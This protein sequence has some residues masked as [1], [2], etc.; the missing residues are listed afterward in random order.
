[1]LCFQ[2]RN[3]NKYVTESDG[4]SL[5]SVCNSN[6]TKTK[7][8]WT[9]NSKKNFV[10]IHK[11]THTQFIS[12]WSMATFLTVLSTPTKITIA[13]AHFV[14]NALYYQY[15]IQNDSHWCWFVGNEMNFSWFF[16]V[17]L[18]FGFFLQLSLGQIGW[19]CEKHREKTSAFD[20]MTVKR[21][22][23]SISFRTNSTSIRF[24]SKF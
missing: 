18:Q 24:P 7:K 21:F 23:E 13:I 8:T 12:S 9:K 19:K 20:S 15:V 2:K 4:I 11:N 1:M 22:I 16:F 6:K 10:W 3:T 5:N 14:F 17:K